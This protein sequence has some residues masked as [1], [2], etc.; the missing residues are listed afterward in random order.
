MGRDASRE[1]KET[2]V[3]VIERVG[4]GSSFGQL[5]SNWN[6]SPT[7]RYRLN[8]SAPATFSLRS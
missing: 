8:I 6:S 2:I 7:L 3:D 5:L 4:C 1:M